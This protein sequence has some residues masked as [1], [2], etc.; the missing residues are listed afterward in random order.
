MYQMCWALVENY[1]D[2]VLDMDDDRELAKLNE[3]VRKIFNKL[4]TKFSKFST[5]KEMRTFAEKWQTTVLMES[6]KTEYLAIELP[7]SSTEMAKKIECIRQMM[8]HSEWATY[9]PRVPTDKR[10]PKRKFSETVIERQLRTQEGRCAV[11][12]AVLSLTDAIGHHIQPWSLGGKTTAENCRVVSQ[13]G[14]D[15][16]HAVSRT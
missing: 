11:T 8:L 2:D 4:R 15:S 3:G 14:H 10:D 5:E 16:L 1:G 6:Y 7:S 12:G 13:A 9:M